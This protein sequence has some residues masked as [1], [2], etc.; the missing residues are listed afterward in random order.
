MTIQDTLEPKVVFESVVGW[1]YAN[2]KLC[3]FGVDDDDTDG[4]DLRLSG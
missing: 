1:N 4:D 2:L 3:C